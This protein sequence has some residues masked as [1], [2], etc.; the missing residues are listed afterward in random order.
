MK[1]PCVFMLSDAGDAV[2]VSCL[3]SAVCG[4]GLARECI[5]SVFW[6]YPVM[7]IAIKLAYGATIKPVFKT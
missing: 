1:S 5:N 7:R 6:I 2:V 3:K 4:S